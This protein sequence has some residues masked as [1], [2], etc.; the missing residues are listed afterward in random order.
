MHQAYPF[1]EVAGASLIGADF[2]TIA[3]TEHR[4]E[5]FNGS[6][7]SG[8]PI[9]FPLGSF[10]KVFDYLMADCSEAISFAFRSVS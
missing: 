1:R 2:Y 7:E 8:K 3:G 5:L 6:D 10:G 9:N 4:H